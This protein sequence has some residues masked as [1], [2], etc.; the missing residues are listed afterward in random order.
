VVGFAR[1]NARYGVWLNRAPV[2]DFQGLSGQ[3]LPFFDLT[4]RTASGPPVATD[5]EALAEDVEGR[6]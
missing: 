5:A 1:P 3:P 4:F 2:R 6:R